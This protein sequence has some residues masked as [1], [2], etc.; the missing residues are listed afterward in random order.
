MNP[1]FHICFG[2]VDQM[3]RNIFVVENFLIA[4]QVSE[5]CLLEDDDVV[6]IGERRRE[7]RHSRFSALSPSSGNFQ[8]AHI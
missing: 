6:A 4:L 5:I 2:G 8:K 3:K 1:G 7:A